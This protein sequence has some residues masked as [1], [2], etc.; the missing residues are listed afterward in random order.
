MAR[1]QTLPEFDA[2]PSIRITNTMPEHPKAEVLSDAAFRA[3]IELWCWCSRQ[4]TDGQV[5]PARMA[6]VRPKAK[7]ELI[8]AGWVIPGDPYRM[9]DYL[10]HQRSSVEIQSFRASQ[11]ES[12]AKGAHMRWH[13]PRRVRSKDC[14]Y[15]LKEVGSA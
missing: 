6:K 11:A 9:H 7:A 5:I 3:L 14:P 10:K 15:C 1:D 12:G 2:R 13:V 8:A 4:E